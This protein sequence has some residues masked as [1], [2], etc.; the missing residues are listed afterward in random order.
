M[1]TNRWTLVAAYG[2]PLLIFSIGLAEGEDAKPTYPIMAP[3]AQYSGGPRSEEIA[4]A[5][6]AAPA[7]IATNADVLTL[8][9][10]GYET[11]VKGKNGFVCV[12][13]RSW[14]TDFDDAQF[15]NPK[16]RAP[17]CFNPTAAHSVLAGYLER[18]NWVLAGISKSE[19][20][21]RTKAAV[22]ANTL[23]LP[24]AGAMC[25]MMSKRGYLNDTAGHWH[26]HLMFF[27]AH[28][29]GTAWGADLDGSPIFAAQGN[30]EPI[31]TFFVL[32]AKWSDGTP[33]PTPVH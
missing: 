22:A 30:P 3:I 14:A 12:V 26:P 27:V 7:S 5:Q 33:A 19:M 2:L 21:A 25:Y 24:E 31:T 17:I 10:H 6:S 11:A 23:L 1:L 29:D 4:L 16:I 13:E 18:T 20:A 28:T 32:V 8:D 15:W 9:S